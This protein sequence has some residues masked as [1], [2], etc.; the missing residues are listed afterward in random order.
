M[1][2][3]NTPEISSWIENPTSFLKRF[4]GICHLLF[5]SPIGSLG[6]VWEPMDTGDSFC[7]PG[8]PTGNDLLCLPPALTLVSC[9]AYPSNLK[10]EAT[11]SSL[12]GLH[13]VIS[14]KLELFVRTSNIT[15][16]G[17]HKRKQMYL[18]FAETLDSEGELCIVKFGL[19]C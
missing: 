17:L 14:H 10:M 2:R 8:E 11:C 5:L 18:T 7:P 4:E 9:L 19:V 13:G 15:A 16:L 3:L 6:S 12:S 1:H